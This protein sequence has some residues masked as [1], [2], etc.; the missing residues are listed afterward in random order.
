MYYYAALVICICLTYYYYYTVQLIYSYQQTQNVIEK[1]YVDLN[2]RITTLNALDDMLAKCTLLNSGVGS[3]LANG[4]KT[5]C[6]NMTQIEVAQNKA[7]SNTLRDDANNLRAQSVTFKQQLNTIANTATAS[8]KD[9]RLSAT[10]FANY[11]KLY[12]DLVASI[13]LARQ[14]A[15]M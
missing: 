5:T 4:V 14:Y 8:I 11:S 2:T 15:L 10:E 13:M 12:S 6:N 3:G 7:A 1:L 9:H